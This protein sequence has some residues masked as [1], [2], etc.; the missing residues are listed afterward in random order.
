MGMDT[1]VKELADRIWGQGVAGRITERI[2]ARRDAITARHAA[3]LGA[4]NDFP[5][6][7]ADAILITYADSLRRE[8][9]APLAT[10]YRFVDEVTAGAIGCVHLLPFFPYS[11][12]A[13]FS[14][15][16]Y[17][18]V[19]AELGD[20][21]E[22][23]ALADNYRVM[24]D[25]V[26]NHCSVEHPWFQ[27]FLAGRAPGRDYFVTAD[28]AADLSR[29][30]RPRAHPL[31]TRFE[32]A[33]GPRHV[34]T[35][36][37]ADQVD[38]DWS[39]PDLAVEMIDTLLEYLERG[40]SI[41]RLD[42]VAFLWK[43]V[44]TTCLHLPETHLVVKLL[45]RVMELALPGSLLITETNVPHDE[46]ISYFAGGD[47]A[48]LVYNFSLPPLVADALIRQDATHLARWAASLQAPGPGRCFFN[49]CASHDGI[50]LTPTRG[51]LSDR[52]R[53]Q[54]IETVQARGGLVS[55]KATPDGP[56]PYELNINYLSAVADP[57][58]PVDQ[59]ARW[60]LLS[61]A[62]MLAFAG[63]PGVY[64]HSLL[65]SENWQA[66]PEGGLEHRSINREP[67]QVSEVEAALADPDSLRALVFTGYRAL[68]D[69][70]ATG[71]AFHPLSP[72]RVHA[73]D[74]GLLAIERGP[75][76]P[77]NE[78]VLCLF[79]VGP[80]EAEWRAALRD[81]PR[82][83]IL[84]DLVTGDRV[85]PSIEA[86]DYSLE[87]LPGEFLWLLLGDKPG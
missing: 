71:S 64:V 13:G 1:R 68:L 86:R 6:S 16:D 69:A 41:V 11:S 83:R 33:S 18:R 10:I 14:I 2:A 59:R 24:V 82:D 28:P 31:L 26:L 55:Y 40:A 65:G 48:H 15:S 53:D 45:R 9:V 57:A 73:A 42:A 32:T 7:E 22:I 70:R 52:E 43:R 8:G 79:N 20:W 19:R 67:L 46:N 27:D 34:W 23:T 21:S 4:M 49:F 35:T 74:S 37:S 58:L 54:L 60:F 61:Q 72:Q 17:R 30:F 39:N 78:R 36:F 66:G 76:G 3:G 87:L 47:E 44:G 62:I 50:G 29:V 80:T 12:D 75:F 85:Y 56:V 25:L 5:L 51:L 84:T 63:V 38:L 77:D 81:L